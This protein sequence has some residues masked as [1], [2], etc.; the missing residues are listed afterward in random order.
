MVGQSPRS[1]LIYHGRLVSKDDTNPGGNRRRF[2]LSLSTWIFISLGLGIGCGLFFGEACRRL[3]F[4]GDGFIR[5][6]QMTILPYI[7][8]SLVHS[9]GALTYE[10]AKQLAG[11]V[12]LILV[13]LWLLTLMLVYVTT[14]AFPHLESASFFSTSQLSPP[15]PIDL[16]ALYIPT[17]P[18]NALAN[19]VIP[20]VVLFSIVT[21]VALIGIPGKESLLEPLATISKALIRVANAVATLT[22]IGVFALA[23]SA[24]GTMTTEQL[25]R[26]QVYLIGYSVMALLLTFCIMPM[27]VSMFTPFR[28]RD[29]MRETKDALLIGFT[30]ANLFVTLPL[31]TESCRRLFKQYDIDETESMASV[32][33]ILPTVFSFPKVGKVLVLLFVP[34]AGWYVGEPMEAVEFVPFSFV[35][36]LTF[37]GSPTAALPFLLDW[38]RIPSD[39]FEFYIVTS[40]IVDRLSIL[41]SGMHMVVIALLVTGMTLGLIAFRVRQVI[42][43][44]AGIIIM[45]VVVVAGMRVY[46]SVAVKAEPKDRVLAQ[47]QILD[48]TVEAI[49][50]DEAPERPSAPPAGTSRLKNILERGTLRVGFV[51]D[52]LPWS[53]FNIR[54]ELVGFDVE[55]AHRLANEL[56][57][58]LEFIPTG[59]TAQEKVRQLMHDE[60]DVLMSGVPSTPDAFSVIRFSRPYI[61]VH[62]AIAVRDHDR[63]R[64]DT[65]EEINRQEGLRIGIPGSRGYFVRSYGPCCRTRSWS[66]SRARR[67]SSR[68]T[69]TASTPRSCPRRAAAPG[70]WSTRDTPWCSCSPRSPSRW[71]T[72]SPATTRSS[73]TF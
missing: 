40:V 47:M 63:R 21:G 64:F 73:R 25:G 4:I 70:R 3:D 52:N 32:N 48:E 65:L 34:F 24:A 71:A 20:A 18:F 37:F 60:F 41:A 42:T 29:V 35:G 50:H 8:V 26:V 17:N 68:T 1:R 57:V 31:L 6:L 72:R 12:G 27:L 2:R 13:G 46:L 36:L 66:R 59:R 7:V 15:V 11:R 53:Y 51:K 43:A 62:A 9:I 67:T 19:Q 56:D 61:D 38:Q 16:T 69:S 5:L 30:T 33:V 58:T 22:P 44:T 55:M 23:A 10:R 39:L 14:L 28:Y 45:T 49:V 54:G